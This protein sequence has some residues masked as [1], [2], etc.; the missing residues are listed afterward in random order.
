[1]EQMLHAGRACF[2]KRTAS[3]TI[4]AAFT[5]RPPAGAR[6]RAFR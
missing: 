4:A 5:P 3:G 6:R 2:L 1:M